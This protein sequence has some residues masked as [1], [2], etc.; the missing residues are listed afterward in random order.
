M[1]AAGVTCSDC[2]DPH[3]AGLRLPGQSVCYQ[4]HEA[5]RYASPKHHFHPEDSTGASCIE[6]HMPAT[7]YMVVD[8]RHDHGFRIPR[9]AQSAR[10]ATPDACTK[11]HEGKRAGWAAARAAEWYGPSAAQ[12]DEYA[13]AMYAARSGLPGAGQLL[14]AI[15]SDAGRPDISRATALGELGANADRGA[16]ALIRAELDANA[17]LRRLGALS[18]LQS[19]PPGVRILAAPLLWDDRKAIRIEALLWDDRK[20]IRIEAAQLLLEVPVDRLPTQVRARMGLVLEEY[21]R[22]QEFAAE[23]PESQLNL[24]R[25]YAVLGGYRKAEAAYRRALQLQPRFVP[26][27][28]NMAQF[29]S[30]RQ[31]EPEAE[32]LLR[33][34]LKLNPG[35]ADLSHALGLSL[36]RSK[37]AD[38]ALAMLARAAELAPENARYGYVYA[39][40]LKSSGKLEESL[41]VLEAANQRHPGDR[42]ILIALAT[43][44]REAGRSEAALRFARELATVMPDDPA[45][46]A[47]IRELAR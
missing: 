37:E 29:L 30:R 27:Y 28:V 40:A 3:A 20:A 36:V 24:A 9:P 25:F 42:D 47:L 7:S 32:G 46:E 14:R 45:L 13:E 11:C 44:N 38:E 6:C 17:P 19:A 31:R 21:V 12:A 4:C 26:A 35:S 2:H 43:F 41:R 18:A 23:R 8:A 39:V 5:Q 33:H 10:L 22:V 16:L 1:H 34:G 15:A